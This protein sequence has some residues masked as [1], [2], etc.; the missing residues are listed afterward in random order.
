MLGTVENL[1]ILESDN[2]TRQAISNVLVEAGYDCTEV[3][4]ANEARAQLAQQA[5]ALVLCNMSSDD[6]DSNNLISDVLLHN[7]NLAAVMVVDMEDIGNL[8]D[9]MARGA[10]ACITKPVAPGQVLFSV[11]NALQRRRLELE[12]Q[13]MR[14]EAESIDFEG[15][16]RMLSAEQETIQRLCRAADNIR[17]DPSKSM[18]SASARMAWCS[19]SRRRR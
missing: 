16:E 15:S 7:S 4:S 3:S 2:L 8:N 19:S 14:A 11:S 5:Y 12:N 9:T 10:Y 17:S 6:D 1:L 18:D 13:A